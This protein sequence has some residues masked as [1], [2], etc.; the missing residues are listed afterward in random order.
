M[1]A[2]KSTK[3]FSARAAALRLVLLSLVTLALPWSSHGASSKPNIILCMADDQGWGD[4]GYYGHQ[5][6]KTPNFDTLAK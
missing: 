5:V 4:M 2:N 1:K 3:P 6:L